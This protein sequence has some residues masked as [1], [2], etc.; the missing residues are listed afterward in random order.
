MERHRDGQGDG[1]LTPKILAKAVNEGIIKEM[2]DRE[3]DALALIAEAS[4][5]EAFGH[6][7]LS[8][9]DKE[10]KHWDEVTG[11][12]LD[13]AGVRKARLEEIGHVHNVK[14]YT[15]VPIQQCWD[16]TGKAPISWM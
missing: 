11:K 16:R 2:S 14:M 9:M 5:A 6:Q 3:R 1:P 15:K 8:Y 7:D 4:D 10:G 12:Q 13:S